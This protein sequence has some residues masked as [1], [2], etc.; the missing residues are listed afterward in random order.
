MFSDR[1]EAGKKLAQALKGY[2]G[3][4]VVVYA[5]PRG[6]VVLGIEVA[7][8]LNAPLDLVLPRKIGHPFHPEYAIC[9]V[10]ESGQLV[11]NETEKSSIDQ[12][13]LK[14]EVIKEQAEAKRRR[15]VYLKNKSLVSVRGKIAIIVD[16]GVATGLTLRAGIKDV[17]SKKPS[18]VVL[19][20]PVCPKD[21][22]QILRQESDKLVALNIPDFYL[23]AVGSYYHHFDQVKDEEVINTLNSY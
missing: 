5:L 11:C 8:A 13:W 14:L 2:Q 20:V 10:T 9:A 22:A 19:A 12:A 4:D 23:G 15:N 21:I 18:Q 3:Q 1:A 16:D 6:G 17:K 7:K